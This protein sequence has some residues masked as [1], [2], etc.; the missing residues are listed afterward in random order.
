MPFLCLRIDLDYVP[1]D[2]PDAAEFGH[3]E[4]AMFL[5]L[6]DL[7]R[8]S[9]YRF[10]FFVSNRVL[11]AF[12][13]T[14][15]AVLNEGHDLDWF[16]KHPE[17]PDR[18]REAMELFDAVGHKPVGLCTRVAWPE[19]IAAPDGISFLSSPPGHVPSGLKHFAVDTKADRDALRAGVSARA[20][21]DAIKAQLRDMASRNRSLTVC[22]RPQVLA[23]YDLRL[24]QIKEILDL[25]RA[26]GLPLRTL[27][28]ELGTEGP[29]TKD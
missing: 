13:A 2:T 17:E 16:A 14:A 15:E 19:G 7:A 26:V 25:S 11:R 22:V 8:N 3:G 9:G 18:Y 27:R 28:Q 4:P 6:L 20:W 21:G 24:T 10:Q 5:K 1:W 29:G 12:P 23:K